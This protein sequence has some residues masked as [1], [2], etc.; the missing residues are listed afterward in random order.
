MQS[1]RLIIGVVHLS[2]QASSIY[3]DNYPNETEELHVDK[4]QTSIHL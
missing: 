4:P 2:I 3:P 1:E